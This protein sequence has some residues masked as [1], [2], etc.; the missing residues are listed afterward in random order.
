ML[1]GHLIGRE[2]ASVVRDVAEENNNN[3]LFLRLVQA[4]CRQNLVDRRRVRGVSTATLSRLA[5]S[6]PGYIS[7]N[8]FFV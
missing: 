4:F 2:R 5:A 7:A 3:E 1:C 6:L 8:C